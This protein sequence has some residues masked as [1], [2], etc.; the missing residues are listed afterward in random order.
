MII[1][2]QQ[3]EA[4]N[5][6]IDLLKKLRTG[7]EQVEIVAT[8]SAPADSLAGVCGQISFYLFG[9][10]DQTGAQAKIA[11][12]IVELTTAIEQLSIRLANP[13]FIAKAPK[14]IILAEQNKLA[15]WQAELTALNQQ[16]TK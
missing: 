4:L 3:A 6:Q 1:A 9:Q 2:G 13:E 11:K 7:L 5:S 12:K 10:I 8:G 16:I 15:D 14:K